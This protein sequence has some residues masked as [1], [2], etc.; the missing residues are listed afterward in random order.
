MIKPAAAAAACVS[1]SVF[2]LSH[3]FVRSFDDIDMFFIRSISPN[4]RECDS[5]QKRQDPF[6]SL[7]LPRS[8]APLLALSCAYVY[9]TKENV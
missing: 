9:Q 1:E 6:P 7:S 5:G 2:L 3:G 4:K 8:P